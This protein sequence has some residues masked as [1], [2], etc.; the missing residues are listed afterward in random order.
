MK[1]GRIFGITTRPVMNFG[2]LT[3]DAQAS[4]ADWYRTMIAVLLEKPFWLR[5]YPHS[6]SLKKRKGSKLMKVGNPLLSIVN[7]TTPIHAQT[8][9]LI[10]QKQTTSMFRQNAP[11][12]AHSTTW[13][14]SSTLCRAKYQLKKLAHL[15]RRRIAN[16]YV[17]FV[18]SYF[19]GFH[20]GKLTNKPMWEKYRSSTNHVGEVSPKQMVFSV[21]LLHLWSIKASSARSVRRLFKKKRF[22]RNM[23]LPTLALN[24]SNASIAINSSVMQRVFRLICWSTKKTKASDASTAISLLSTPR[25][26]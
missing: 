25:D 17:S 7:L 22:L 23:F 9:G 21:M 14:P 19:S 24:R 5:T 15:Q 18:K 20:I 2:S 16:F 3:N 26:L 13:W 10:R 4:S 12:L 1:G 8:Q 11:F 6:L